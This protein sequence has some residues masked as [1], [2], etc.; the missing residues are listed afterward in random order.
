MGRTK[1]SPQRLHD[2]KRLNI[3]NVIIFCEG[4]TEKYYFDYFAEIM[5]RSK[6]TN[7]EVVLKTANGNAKT[8]LNCA[9]EFMRDEANSQKYSNYEKYLAFDCDDPPDVQN[10]I[11]E[12][13]E[14]EYALL[15]SNHLFETWL[16][17]HFEDV[18]GKIS[19]SEIYRRLSSHLHEQ[20]TK[21]DKGK[22]REIIQNGNIEKAIDNARVLE[23]K[24]AAKGKT[25]FTAIKEMN[26]FTNVYTLVEQFMIDL[27]DHQ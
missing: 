27:S 14:E 8:V 24:Y 15:I 26:P 5:K 19:K 22:T 16:L 23:T 12:A 25:I 4:K 2:T 11:I 17:M 21:G 3:G 7:I 9:N 18:E 20:Y 6:Y 1:L 13:K 10:V